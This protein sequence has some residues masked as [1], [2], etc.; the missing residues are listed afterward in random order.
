MNIIDNFKT[1]LTYERG[2]SKNSVISYIKDLENFLNMCNKDLREIRQVDVV[3]Y[4]NTLLK[5]GLKVSTVTRKT[6]TLKVFFNY[7]EDEGVVDKTP[8]IKIKALKKP[9]TLPKF[10]SQKEIES[11]IDTAS[12]RGLKELVLLELLYGVGG[13]VSEIVSLKVSDIDLTDSVVRITKGKGNKERHN[14]IHCS[15]LIKEYINKYK[16]KDYLFP[17]SSGNKPI[18]RA[19][20]F[21]IVKRL[22]RDSGIDEN[23]VSPHVFRH[24]FATH[25]LDGGSQIAIVQELLGH[26]D[27]S[28]TKIYAKVTMTAKHDSYLKHHPRAKR[29]I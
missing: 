8:I 24:S 11:L 10:I 27:I 14:P 7:L 22:A 13:R 21:N 20:V 19:S 17:N 5:Q 15:P 16:I 28:T 26:E 23:K 1:H 25:L 2:L 29:Y 18:T 4:R 9:S 3:D 12:K 6:Q